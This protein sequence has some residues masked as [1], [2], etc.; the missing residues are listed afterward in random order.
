L[1]LK[2][3]VEQS[4]SINQLDQNQMKITDLKPGDTIQSLVSMSVENIAI[5]QAVFNNCVLIYHPHNDSI[6][7]VMES[8]LE[9]DFEVCSEVK[10]I[11]RTELCE[12]FN[13]KHVIIKN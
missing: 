1:F 4:K 9:E 6:E 11:S 3:N 13:V 5:V 2:P 7:F 8:E 10:T 12:L